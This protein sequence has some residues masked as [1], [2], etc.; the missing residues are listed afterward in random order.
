MTKSRTDGWIRDGLGAFG[1]VLCLECFNHNLRYL[2]E[3][4]IIRIYFGE[5]CK[6][7][8]YLIVQEVIQWR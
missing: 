8:S 2:I 4:Y 5:I 6:K 7:Y 3:W 1:P